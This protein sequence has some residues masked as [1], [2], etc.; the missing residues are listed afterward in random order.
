MKPIDYLVSQGFKESPEIFR[1]RVRCFYKRFATPTRCTGNEDKPGIQVCVSVYEH[2]GK[3]SY[4]LDICGGLSDG[5]WINLENYALS[6][7]IKD[8][9]DAI[10]R[11]IA[12]WEFIAN[13]TKLMAGGFRVPCRAVDTEDL[14]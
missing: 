14:A 2:D 8:V 10:P 4:E 7:N 3:Y 11:L 9:I 6:D 1:M 12:A 13:S 5:T